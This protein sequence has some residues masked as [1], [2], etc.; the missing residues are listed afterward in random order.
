MA[1][2]EGSQ[3]ILSPCFDA[4][5][6]KTCNRYQVVSM[7]GVA[8][9]TEVVAA[10]EAGADI[11]KVFPGDVFGPDYFKA[12]RAPLPHAPLMPSGGVTLDNIDAWFESGAVA[13]GVGG[14]LTKAALQG[15][16]AQVTRNAKAFVAACQ[17]RAP[18]ATES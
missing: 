7:P 10:M 9:A 12:L 17:R 5:V 13:V 18:H 11:I 14:S 3:F 2:L 1:I 4:P 16:Y 8:T 15:D 6:V